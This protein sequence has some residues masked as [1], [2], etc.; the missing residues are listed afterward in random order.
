MKQKTLFLSF[1]LLT[2]L[3]IGFI[4]TSCESYKFDFDDTPQGNIDALWTIL[5]E[6]YCYFNYKEIDW[7]SIG[8]S[9]RARAH[10]SVLR[11]FVPLGQTKHLCSY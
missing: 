1:A 7:D 10:L 5:D 9:Y 4:G 11:A 2:F 6:N 8:A 3:S